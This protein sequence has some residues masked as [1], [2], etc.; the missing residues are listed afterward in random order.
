MT[1]EAILAFCGGFERNRFRFRK[2]W[3]RLKSWW[4]DMCDEG[5]RNANVDEAGL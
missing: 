5:R 2:Q 1:I 3:P 4:W